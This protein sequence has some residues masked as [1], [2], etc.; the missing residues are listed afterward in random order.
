MGVKDILERLT[1]YDLFGYAFPGSI[2]VLTAIF[3][4]GNFGLWE[5]YKDLLPYITLAAGVLSYLCGLF[6]SEL[7][8]EIY[9]RFKDKILKEEF[10]AWSDERAAIAA[11]IAKHRNDS[12]PLVISDEKCWEKCMKYMYSA[13][14]ISPDT[15]RIHNYA[16]TEVMCR[17]LSCTCLISGIILTVRFGLYMMP[18]A[19]LLA[20]LM[21]I[22]AR[23]FGKKKRDYTVYWFLQK[24]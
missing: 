16:S 2:L 12:A 1:L 14:Q 24:V 20:V 4:H 11:A 6:L 5:K 3:C 17:N 10:E 8:A 9:M 21:E 19:A 7:S 22:R 23:R 13:V 18:A 15:K